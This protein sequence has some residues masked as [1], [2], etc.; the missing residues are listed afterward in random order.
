MLTV[1]SLTGFSPVND[2]LLFV[3]TQIGGGGGGW[4]G[5]VLPALLPQRCPVSHGEANY[6][7][8]PHLSNGALM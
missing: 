7:L 6:L 2:L 4:G 8:Y 5:R 3:V 1:F